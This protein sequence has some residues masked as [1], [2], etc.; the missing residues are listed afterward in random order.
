MAKKSKAGKKSII[1]LGVDIVSLVATDAMTNAVK[2]LEK[3]GK[4]NRKDAQKTLNSV[5]KRYKAASER[6]AKE[7]QVQLDRLVK[8]SVKSNPFVTQKDLDELRNRMEK[9]DD[10]LRKSKK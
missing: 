10:S 5:A 7:L 1:D 2:T 4:L 3:E 9:L 8:Q 6:Y